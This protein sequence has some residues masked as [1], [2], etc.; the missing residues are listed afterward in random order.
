LQHGEHIVGNVESARKVRRWYT[1]LYVQVLIAVLI[2]CGIGGFFPKTGMALK[3]LGDAFVSLIRMMIAPVIFCVIVQGIASMSDLKKVGTLGVK[4]LIY[5]EV[6]S[7]LALIIGIL[8]AVVFHPGAGLNIDAATLDPKAAAVFVGRAKETGFIPFLLGFIPRTFIG[9]LADGEVP[10]VL[11]ISILTGFAIANMGE[12]GKRALG[13]IEVA[14]KVVFGIVRIVV[15]A[16]PLG[17]LGGMAFTVGSYGVASLANLLKLMGT[18]Y[19]SSFLFVVVVLGIIARLAG[20]SI[21]RFLAYIKDELLIVLGT[22]SSE[23]VL[24]DMM[25]KLEGLGASRSTV[26]LVF[27]TGYVF[28]TDG[29]NIYLTL[30]AL[31]LAQATNTHLSLGQI[32]GIL[33]FALVASKGGSGVTGTGFV[34]LAAILAAVPSIPVQSLALL[35]GIEKFMSECRALTNVVGNGVA[36]LV[37]SRWEGE[38]DV[39]NMRRVMEKPPENPETNSA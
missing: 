23:T 6:V 34:T 22:S 36:T 20:F 26:G 12:V 5:F 13:A 1:V 28:N 27:P 29:T 9:A 21:F 35:V 16:A 33:L 10:Q 32:S 7:T 2:G 38:L 18:F 11:L 14:N 8:V 4:T 30:A 39:E 17:A 3:P 24:P 31:F 19:L 15:R 37:I 25:R